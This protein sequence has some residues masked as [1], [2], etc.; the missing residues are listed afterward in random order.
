MADSLSAIRYAHVCHIR[1]REGYIVDFEVTGFFP[2]FG[3]DDDRVDLLAKDLTHRMII[4]LRRT[5]A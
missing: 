3:N 2:K 4:E 1:S 5:P